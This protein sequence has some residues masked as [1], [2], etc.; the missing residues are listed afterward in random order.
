[1]HTLIK[2]RS[3]WLDIALLSAAVCFANAPVRAQGYPAKPVRIVVPF[4]AGG[5]SE[6]IARAIGM[7]LSETL[8]QPFVIDLRP[9][10]A[11]LIGTLIVQRA[12]A[13]GH[14][15]LLAD[16]GFTIA[17]ISQARPPFDPLEDF[18]P[19][20][21]IATTP[22]VLMAHPSFAPGMK[23]LLALP[24]IQSERI[25]LGTSGG[26]PQMTY[27]LLRVRTGLVLT[28]IS[29]KGGG[30]ALTDA[31]AG[32]V[33]LVFTSL[34]AGN[35]Y[36]RTG[37][38]KGLAITTKARHPAAPEVPTFTE[39]GVPDFVMVNWY[40]LLAPTRTPA[41]AIEVL[42]REVDR[43]LQAP[44]ARERLA[45]LGFDVAASSRESLATMLKA[46]LDHWRSVARST[47]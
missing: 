9:G 3:K 46:E 14:T 25:A 24:R 10:A 37:R 21:L 28:E 26:T 44:E 18:T 30:P 6:T 33:P 38:L 47:R 16:S 39:A 29:Y 17:S 15:L 5:G 19:V 27:Q 34:A 7:K 41:G 32:Q 20:A 23:E 45:S 13:D 2:G 11:S 22:R 8:G 12:P 1:M 36:L 31:I 35:P 40:G 43:A 42:A 4:A